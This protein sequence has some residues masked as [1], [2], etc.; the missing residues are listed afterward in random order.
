MKRLFIFLFFILGSHFLSAQD[1]YVDAVGFRGGPTL[2]VSYKRFVWPLNGVLE[3][4]VGFNFQN[5]RY[6]HVTGLYEYHLFLNYSTN[7]Y[8]GGGITLG[9]NSN[10]F[11]WQ[12]ESVVGIEYIL[13]FLPVNISVDYKPGFRVLDGDFVLNEFGISLRYI[14]NQ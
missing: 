11:V 12:L 6:L 9:G 1:A 5:G 8:G 3:G 4:I 2:G 10:E 7:L 13:D 14:L